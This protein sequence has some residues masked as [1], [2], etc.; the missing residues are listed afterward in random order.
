[1]TGNKLLLS[2][3]LMAHA[4][5]QVW[6]GISDAR[7]TFSATEAAPAGTTAPEMARLTENL[8]LQRALLR[9]LDTTPSI[10]LLDKV[11]VNSIEKEQKEGGGWPLVHLSDGRV[12]RA[13]LLVTPALNDKK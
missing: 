13:R 6:D 5:L 11:K 2:Q 9:Y 3:D 8:N 12:L 1:M 10:K 7:I 4:S